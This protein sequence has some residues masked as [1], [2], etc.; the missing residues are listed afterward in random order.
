MFNNLF[1]HFQLYCI[2]GTFYFVAFTATRYREVICICTICMYNVHIQKNT[3]YEPNLLKW[4]SGTRNFCHFIDIDIV[5]IAFSWALNEKTRDQP[6]L[7]YIN[8]HTILEKKSKNVV[9]QNFGLDF[10][11][12]IWRRQPVVRMPTFSWCDV[13]Y[14]HIFF[15]L[16]ILQWHYRW[17]KLRLPVHGLAGFFLRPWVNYLFSGFDATGKLKKNKNNFI[18]RIDICLTFSDRIVSVKTNTASIL[19]GWWDKVKFLFACLNMNRTCQ[20]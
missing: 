3:S 20:L 15:F 16:G 2:F 11:V 9:N 14:V 5:C 8:L 19:C 10:C 12:V 17:A 6:P 7:Q 4:W 1:D 13:I 18:L